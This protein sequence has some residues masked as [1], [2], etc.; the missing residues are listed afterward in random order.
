[1]KYWNDPKDKLKNKD[2]QMRS[3]WSIP[4]LSKKEKKFGKHPTQK[5]LELL[6]RI[7]ISSSK[8]NDVV[9]DP[10]VGSGTTGIIS[11]LHKRKFI[12]IDNNKDYLDL[13]IKRFKDNEYN[14]TLLYFPKEK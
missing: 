11:N 7:I 14:R 6:N 1:M 2:K 13:A 8:E 9:L 10:F 4:L 12:G 3:V 5:P